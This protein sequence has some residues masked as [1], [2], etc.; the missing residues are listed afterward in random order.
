VAEILNAAY[1]VRHYQRGG[2]TSIGRAQRAQA[3]QRLGLVVRESFNRSD[4]FEA[5]LAAVVAGLKPTD[6]DPPF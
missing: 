2:R 4:D 6:Y 5:L 1:M 3:I